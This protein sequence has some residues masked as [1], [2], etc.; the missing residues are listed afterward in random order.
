MA[1]ENA[2]FEGLH[3]AIARLLNAG[4][5]HPYHIIRDLKISKTTVMKVQRQVKSGEGV[6]TKP[7]S[8]TPRSVRTPATIKTTKKIVE[9]PKDQDVP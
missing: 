8:M 3:I 1:S 9:D 7:R 5:H 2:K 6:N 4:H